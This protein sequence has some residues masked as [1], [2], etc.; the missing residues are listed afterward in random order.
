[1]EVEGKKYHLHANKIRKYV[2][3]I[4]QAIISNCAVIYDQGQ[5]FGK[6]ELIGEISPPDGK[7]S[8]QLVGTDKV[9]HLKPLWYWFNM[10]RLS[11]NHHSL[12]ETTRSRSLQRE[13]VRQI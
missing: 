2:D 4:V 1:M 9:N 6:I 12:M 5:G 7:V 11:K 3:R 13:E 10:F 8:S